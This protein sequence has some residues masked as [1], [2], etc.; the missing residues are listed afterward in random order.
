[1]VHY[2]LSG[3]HYMTIEGQDPI[4]CW[5]GSVVIIPPA[6][7][8]RVAVDQGPAIDTPAHVCSTLTREGL[9]M[10]DA[11]EG[12]ECHLRFVSGIVLA[13]YG[14][15][16]GLFDNLASPV[17]QHIGDYEI[18][19]HAF[20]MMV[21]EVG[22]PD[23]GARALT[24]ALMKTCLVLLIR[25]AL[26]LGKEE[27]SIFGALTD[28]RLSRSIAAVLDRP[29]A[30]HTVD[31]MAE[32]AGMSRSVFCRTFTDAFEM[33]PKDFVSKTRLHH[34]AQ[35]LRSTPLPIKAIATKV[36]FLSRSHFSRAFRMA[37][38]VD[39]TEFRNSKMERPLEPPKKPR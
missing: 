8:P 10:I 27:G 21:E 33:S 22:K 36:G 24:S 9:L 6:H 32:V 15:S 3:E 7:Q 38:G 35:M 13:S 12:G 1:M 28:K 20:A 31:S 37:Y 5:P 2:V 26:E 25:Q 18:V 16:F 17:V 23:L 29:A 30:P 11:T 39:P 34:A 19:R 14:G 4:A